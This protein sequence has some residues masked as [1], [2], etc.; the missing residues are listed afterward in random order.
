LTLDQ[1]NRLVQ[2]LEEKLSLLNEKRVKLEDQAREFAD[3][4]DKLNGKVRNT[5]TECE[6][7]RKERDEINEKVQYLKQ[8]RNELTS[9][10]REK[11]D[12][13]RKLGE[14]SKIIAKKRPSIDHEALQEE[15]ESIDWEI[16]TTPHTL[17][18]D[19]ELV[20][21]V[22]ELENQL[23]FH[24]KYEKL[25]KMIRSLR[26]EVEKFKRE[27]AGYHE[28]L[29]ANAKNSQELHGKMLARVDEWKKLRAEADE[30][31]KKFVLA[32]ESMKL[33]QDEISVA[34]GEMR[35]LK[36]E[37]HSEEEQEKKQSEDQLRQSIE[38]RAKEKLK[39]GEKLSW[40]EFQLLAE[41]GIVTQD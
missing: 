19:R 24:K 39:R 3:K 32:R 31:H 1:K 9:K 26:A 38:N 28:S 2:E 20:E 33:L 41:K 16:Q 34:L 29:T 6:Q 13:I 8:H 14:K 21:R 37:M 27:S 36:G 18:E 40:E 5:R 17:E 23:S 4:R 10:I 11:I 35:K 25:G 30:F 12:E 15:V 7:L 22:M